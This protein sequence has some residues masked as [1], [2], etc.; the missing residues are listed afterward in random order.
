MKQRFFDD[1][2]KFSCREVGFCPYLELLACLFT[3]YNLLKALKCYNFIARKLAHIVSTQFLNGRSDYCEFI[4]VMASRIR[5]T[6]PTY[7]S[8]IIMF[9]QQSVYCR[10]ISCLE[11]DKYVLIISLRLITLN[12]KCARG[13]HTLDTIAKSLVAIIFNELCKITAASHFQDVI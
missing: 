5:R 11:S 10:L 2:V 3:F 6:N 13:F 1:L 4:I 7:F 8:S 12:Y 9:F